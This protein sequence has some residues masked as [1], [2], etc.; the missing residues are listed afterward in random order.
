ML[1]LFKVKIQ[2][3]NVFVNPTYVFVDRNIIVSDTVF[4]LKYTALTIGT[5]TVQHREIL[6][7]NC[8][9]SRAQNK[10]IKQINCYLF[11]V[12]HLRPVVS[13]P[14][15]TLYVQLWKQISLLEFVCVRALTVNYY[16]IFLCLFAFLFIW[17][18]SHSPSSGDSMKF[19]RPASFFSCDL[20]RLSAFQY[21][22]C[23]F[24][25]STL[26]TLS[27]LKSYCQ[28]KSYC[29]LSICFDFSKDHSSRH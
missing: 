13:I 11:L 10:I 26:S 14:P 19:F 23:V 20:R 1:S 24:E 21:E 22:Y 4:T 2:N 5:S 9:C 15:N 29:L 16:S 25:G 27:L 17:V 12:F 28:L 3:F 8:N 7:T 18:F 6:Y